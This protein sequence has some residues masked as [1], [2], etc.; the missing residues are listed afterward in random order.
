MIPFQ[1][2]RRIP[3]VRR[4]FSQRDVALAQAVDLA[5]QLKRAERGHDNLKADLD[6]LKTEHV[7]LAA[8]H[9]ALKGER[10]TLNIECT[11]LRAERAALTAERDTFDVALR[12]AT[13][14]DIAQWSGWCPICEAPATFR[15]ENPW[16]RDHLI[17]QSCHGGSIPR[18]RAI[19]QALQQ[20]RP[21][22]RRLRIHESSPVMRGASLVLERDC[23]RYTPSQ[24]WHDVPVGEVRGGVRCEN[25]ERQTFPD[26]SFDIVI[27]QDV[28]EHLFHPERAVQEIYRTLAPD[29]L[30]LFTVPVYNDLSAT[31][32]Y[33]S[34]DSDRIVY[35]RDP[36][37]HGNP[38]DDKG[39][40]VT[41]HYAKD[42]ATMLPAWADFHIDIIDREDFRHGIAGEFL[43][44]FVCRKARASGE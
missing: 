42:L 33:A 26:E 10:D 15:S 7:H 29:G 37:Y 44:V 3:L 6:A 17:C 16:L 2:H 40:L 31:V 21:N 43:D 1:L 38:I 30:Y 18:E 32:P 35:H 34:L 28:M 13:D 8:G 22:W 14:N 36:E 20:A 12:C 25:I 11:A 41:F 23:P 39:S 4:P 19:M 27:T 9:T 24:F 5:M